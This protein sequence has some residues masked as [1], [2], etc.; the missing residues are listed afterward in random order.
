MKKIIR[1]FEKSHSLRE[2]GKAIGVLLDFIKFHFN[3][4]ELM[5]KEFVFYLM[6]AIEDYFSMSIFSD[7]VVSTQ[8]L[9]S[10]ARKIMTTLRVPFEG[11][12]ICGIQIMGVLESRDLGFHHLI[13][14]DANEG[15]LPAVPTPSPLLPLEIRESMGFPTRGKE[16]SIYAYHFERLVKSSEE[17]TLLYQNKMVSSGSLEGKRT[18]S[19]FIEKLI[20]EFEKETHEL[21]K[22]PDVS[23]KTK[24]YIVNLKKIFRKFNYTWAYRYIFR[25]KVKI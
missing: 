2:L 1:S 8:E 22:G 14:I 25:K 19:R 15:I 20:W 3:N 11:E 24:E 9:Y 10:I 17:V 4:L 12:P 6:G 21:I 18:R 5:E 23:V 13:I 16:E 7:E